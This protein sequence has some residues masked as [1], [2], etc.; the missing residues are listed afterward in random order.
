MISLE[1]LFGIDGKVYNGSKLLDFEIF[2]QFR[3]EPGTFT[4][5]GVS[6]DGLES[7]HLSTFLVKIMQ[8]LL[9]GNLEVSE[10]SA[11]YLLVPYV[12]YL[13]LRGAPYTLYYH[14]IRW[15][16]ADYVNALSYN[17]LPSIS[18]GAWK[19][20]CRQ[21]MEL[22]VA[23]LPAHHGQKSMVATV[24]CCVSRLFDATG[25]GN[26]QMLTVALSEAGELSGWFLPRYISAAAM[27]GWTLLHFAAAHINTDAE[28][29][30]ILV[31]KVGCSVANQDA[32]G[33]NALHVAAA[34]LNCVGVAALSSAP[35]SGIRAV[36]RSGNTPLHL[37]LRAITLCNWRRRVSFADLQGMI[38]ALLPADASQLLWQRWYRPTVQYTAH[39]TASARSAMLYTAVVSTDNFIAEHVLSSARTAPR[40]TW[41]LE[42]I[43]EAIIGCVRS[44][45]DRTATV[46]LILRDFELTVESGA[47][48]SSALDLLDTCLCHAVVTAHRHASTSRTVLTTLLKRLTELLPEATKTT[49]A[50]IPPF[51]FLYLAVSSQNA[52]LVGAVLSH[53]P[54]PVVNSLLYPASPV[55]MTG[56][57][58]Q[59]LVTFTTEV[60]TGGFVNGM[61]SLLS[62]LSLACVLGGVDVVNALLRAGYSALPRR[63]AAPAQGSD[64]QPDGPVQSDYFQ[65]ILHC[66]LYARS[67]C[68]R[69]IRNLCTKEAMFQ[70]CFTEKGKSRLCRCAL[71]VWILMLTVLSEHRR[72]KRQDH[73]YR[74]AGLSEGGVRGSV[75]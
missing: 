50:A 17:I 49:A 23:N 10:T 65:P 15:W 22:D 60:S 7:D 27:N 5:H 61:E 48:S 74:A 39:T 24:E 70:L 66:V 42:V 3:S 30:A 55:P 52:A 59:R 36:D 72:Y 69:T 33:Q 29:Y 16:D 8:S 32:L 62:P 73:L 12:R 43:R 28:L 26:A 64:E 71:W 56:T 38:T 41:D 25:S 37:L 6:L 31:N 34:S 45:Q 51:V 57:F 54:R 67:E 14:S 53:L 40:E 21:L 46:E 2:Q 13:R 35:T 11:K 58:V 68:L 1:E 75:P 4:I 63:A 44:G 9:Q 19:R 20:V 47:G 18:P